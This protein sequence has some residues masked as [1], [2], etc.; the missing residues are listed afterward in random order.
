MAYVKKT[1]TLVAGRH[2]WHLLLA[3]LERGGICG[4][5]EKKYTLVL[6]YHYLH[7]CLAPMERDRVGAF[8]KTY[9]PLCPNCVRGI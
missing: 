5:R 3:P 4:I 9:I 7:L 2:L 1:Y 8:E 6:G